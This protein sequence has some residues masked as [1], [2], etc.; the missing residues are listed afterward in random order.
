[1]CGWFLRI[2]VNAP[3]EVEE[4][5]LDQIRPGLARLEHSYPSWSDYLTMVKAMPY[6]QGWWDPALEAFYRADVVELPSGEVR[7]RINPPTSLCAWKTSWQST[8]SS[9][10]GEFG[11]RR[12]SCG[13]PSHSVHRGIRLSFLGMSRFARWRRFPM[14]H[15]RSYRATTSRVS[16]E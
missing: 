8:S 9:W 1:M 15:W 12:C 5:I 10:Q 7:S 3:A 11:S 14:E 4:G 16:S 2:V 13:H 6:Y